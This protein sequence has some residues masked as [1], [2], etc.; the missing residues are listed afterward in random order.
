MEPDVPTIEEAI[1]DDTLRVLVVVIMLTNVLF[2]M[3]MAIID[4]TVMEL[5]TKV[6]K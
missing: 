1:T 2:T 6:L 3:D 5:P 4:D